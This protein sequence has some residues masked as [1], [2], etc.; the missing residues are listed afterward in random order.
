M[1]DGLAE[2]IARS[3]GSAL[4]LLGQ[5]NRAVEIIN[6]RRDRACFDFNEARHDFGANIGPGSYHL[7][8]EVNYQRFLVML[9]G[10]R[11]LQP[12]K[13]IYLF[14]TLTGL[15]QHNFSPAEVSAEH[16]AD[17][18]TRFAEDIAEAKRSTMDKANAAYGLTL[19]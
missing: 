17:L 18:I 15:R 13:T 16:A 10:E 19:K 9:E 14:H 1:P 11:S 6:E 5:F 12:A 2:K 7:N 8:A 4:Q 3:R